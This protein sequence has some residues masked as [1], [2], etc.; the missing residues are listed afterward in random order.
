MESMSRQPQKKQPGKQ[1]NGPLPLSAELYDAIYSFKDY[2]Q[3]CRGLSNLIDQSMPDA[4]TILDVACGTGEH[5]RFLRDRFEIDGVDI[6]ENYL[7]AARLKNPSGVYACA[8]MTEFDL[9]RTYDVVTCLFSAIGIVSTFERLER[10]IACM[11]RHVKP[12]GTLIVEPWF[13]PE[14]WRPYKPF[15]LVGELGG[16]KVYRTSSG[17]RKPRSS[18]LLHHYLLHTPTTVIDL[19]SER[20]ELAL[21]TR[22]EMTWAFESA[23]MKVRYDSTGLIGRGIYL[24]KHDC[25]SLTDGKRFATLTSNLP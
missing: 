8:D 15:M 25:G 22:D 14:Q 9:G 7:Q 2:A 6:N 17:V 18:V 21:F 1:R 3:E 5:A 19:H 11:A 10:A 12:S 16:G 20:I 23:G 24:G 4:H 13:T